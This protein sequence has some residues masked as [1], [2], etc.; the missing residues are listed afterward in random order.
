MCFSKPQLSSMS[1][2]RGTSNVFRGLA[3]LMFISVLA[4]MSTAVAEDFR[5]MAMPSEKPAHTHLRFYG[6]HILGS[7]DDYRDEIKELA[8]YTNL[9]SFTV[10]EIRPS[11][12]EGLSAGERKKRFAQVSG[13]ILFARELGLEVVIANV[14]GPLMRAE[15]DREPWFAWLREVRKE[16]G[17]AMSEIYAFYIV[18]EP[19]IRDISSDELSGWISEF[20]Q[21]FPGVKCVSTYALVRRSKDMEPPDNLDIVAVD[22]YINFPVTDPASDFV[23]QYDVRFQQALEWVRKANR[24]AFLVADSYVVRHPRAKNPMPE[25]HG[26]LWYLYLALSEPNFEGL[27]WWYYG[28]HLGEPGKPGTDGMRLG[29]FP[30]T[31]KVHRDIGKALLGEDDSSE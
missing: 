14:G 23:T 5:D 31:E 7:I 3:F 18:D 13:K 2:S 29:S 4:A 21:V 12:L 6:Y 20:K 25:E 9:I 17:E 1:A 27:I 15:G 8:S 26:S 16:M 22:P 19:D 10:N 28:V 30:E 11:E 24:P